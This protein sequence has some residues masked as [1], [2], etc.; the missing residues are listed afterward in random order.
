M[1]ESK[2][3]TLAPS[4][5]PSVM[6][7][8]E[9]PSGHPATTIDAG[10][11]EM[12]DIDEK[13]QSI[14]NR[15]VAADASSPEEV[16]DESQYPKSWKLG[17]ISVALCLSVFCMALVRIPIPQVFDAIIATMHLLPCRCF[18]THGIFPPSQPNLLHEAE[19]NSRLGQHH[20]RNRHSTHNRSIPC[21]RRCRLVRQCLPPHNLRVPAVLRKAVHILLDQMDIPGCAL[22]L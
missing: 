5:E 20:H 9:Q 22:H 12:N 3:S 4:H 19:A 1:D 15:E 2:A 13:E 10:R 18:A 16:D 7:K 14:E 8:P 17:L 11:K 21:S 6:E